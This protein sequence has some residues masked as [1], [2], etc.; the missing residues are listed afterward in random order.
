ML[1][2]R[3]PIS[4]LPAGASAPNVGKPATR[5]MAESLLP[6]V[7]EAALQPPRPSR[8]LTPTKRR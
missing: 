8:K 6:H 2:L 4:G 7:A 5:G 1:Q 3:T